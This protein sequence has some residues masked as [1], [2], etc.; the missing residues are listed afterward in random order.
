[1]R[2]SARVCLFLFF[3]LLTSVWGCSGIHEAM[4][5]ARASF[6]LK[7]AYR[8]SY[9]TIGAMYK[10]DPSLAMELLERLSRKH[11]QNLAYR[12]TLA[13]MYKDRGKGN[14]AIRLWF[15]ILAISRHQGKTDRRPLE[16]YF[17]PIVPYQ[18]EGLHRYDV[19]IDKSL[20]YTNIALIYLQNAFFVDAS[21][22]FSKAAETSLDPDR[23]ADLY[24]RAGMAIGSKHVEFTISEKDGRPYQ[25]QADRKVPVDP[26]QYRRKEM[27]FYLMALAVDFSD[28]DLRAKIENNLSSV[29]EQI[30]DYEGE[31][32]G[33]EQKKRVVKPEGSLQEEARTS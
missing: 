13:D 24:H 20:A 25:E 7:Y 16:V 30:I 4:H 23:K 21:E 18:E 2:C 22:Y 33:R 31:L 1:M 28:K 32:P 10:T 11:P 9:N 12:L 6:P 8:P 5:S 17:I 3:L 19:K 15:E 27:A 26:M 14:D 29:Q